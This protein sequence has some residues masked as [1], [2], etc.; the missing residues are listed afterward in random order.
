MN[1][2]NGTPAVG[3]TF[4]QGYAVKAVQ[5]TGNSSERI[6]TSYMPLRNMSFSLHAWIYPTGYP[7]PTYSVICGLC[8]AP[9]TDKCFQIMIRK[10][11]SSQLLYFGFYGD[12]FAAYSWPIPINQ[13]QHIAATF[14]NITRNVVLYLDGIMIRNGTTNGQLNTFNGTFEIGKVPLLVASAQTFKVFDLLFCFM[15]RQRRY[16]IE[17]MQTLFSVLR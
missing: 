11:N 3:L 10:V 5:F 9:S 14:D 7:N 13:W 2:Y 16:S 6:A 17:R 12:D 8:S 1:T 4:V 15:S